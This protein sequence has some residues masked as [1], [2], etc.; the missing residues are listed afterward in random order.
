M[1]G[2]EDRSHGGSHGKVC[3]WLS[4]SRSSA[5]A[6]SARAAALTNRPITPAPAYFG[7]H[8]VEEGTG[9]GVPLVELK[10]VNQ[11]R[12]VTDS[13]GIVAFDEPGLFNRKVFFTITSHGYEVD[14]DGFGYRGK[15]LEVT[16]GGSADIVIRRLNIARRL[17]RVTGAGIYRDSVLT[18]DAVPIREPLLNGKVFGQDSVVNA[19]YQ[20]KIHWFWGDTN[21]PTI[22]SG[23]FMC[24]APPPTCPARGAWSRRSAST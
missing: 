19:V 7:I 12:Y 2:E 9:R 24:R 21:R 3:C 4:P 22:R 1:T 18:G 8:V 5:P 10:T 15:A 17:Y 20:G 14:K 23:I 13:N 11:I 16:E 6:S